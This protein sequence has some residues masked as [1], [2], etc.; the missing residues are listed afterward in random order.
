MWIGC[1]RRRQSCKGV[2]PQDS[3]V[4]PKGDCGTEDFRGG[5]H[6]KGDEESL[7]GMPK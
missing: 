5:C 3:R 1:H 4:G 7:A 2:G 6:G